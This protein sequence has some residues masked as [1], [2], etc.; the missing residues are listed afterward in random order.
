MTLYGLSGPKQITMKNKYPIPLMEDLFDRL[1]GETVF[2]KID[3]KR[4]YWQVRNAERDEHKM[5]CGTRYG[6][7]DF[8][9]MP[10]GLTNS[11]VSFCTLMNQVFGEYIDEF[12]VVHLD[13][14]VIYS[15]TL[16]E[17]LEY[18]RKVLARLREHELYAKLY[19]CAFFQK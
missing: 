9:V 7:Y 8:L 13:D 6:W 2:T 18:L 14:I 10:F 12:V 4:G 15:K 1:D 3:L 11:P 16:E 19:K 5:T 17:Y